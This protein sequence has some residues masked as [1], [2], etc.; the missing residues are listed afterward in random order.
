MK[1]SVL[2]VLLLSIAVGAQNAALPAQQ[3]SASGTT[4]SSPQSGTALPQKSIERIQKEVRHQLV[5]LPFYGVFD[6]LAFQVA[7]DGTVTLLGQVS[8]PTLKSDAEKTVKSIE[9]VE[10]VVNNIEVLPVSPNDDRIRRETYRAIYGNEVLS[11]YQLRAV[12]PIH[13]IVKNGNVTL[14]GVVARQMDK[15]IAEMQAKSVPGA[16]SVTNNLRVENE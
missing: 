12:P 5:L 1:A 2:A 16:F 13:I 9:G 15:Q 3:K 10:R 7:P 11:Q 14:E 4:A 6:N 8:R